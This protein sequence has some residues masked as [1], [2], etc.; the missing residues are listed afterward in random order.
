MILFFQVAGPEVDEMAI[1]QAYHREVKPQTTNLAGYN[2]FIPG[3]HPPHETADLAFGQVW[4]E[5]DIV[6]KQGK[7]IHG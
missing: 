7:S 3:L 4:L 2:T 5:A 6:Q 1:V